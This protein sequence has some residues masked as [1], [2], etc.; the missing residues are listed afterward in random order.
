MKA[1]RPCRYTTILCF[2]GA[3]AACGHVKDADDASPPSSDASSCTPT[4]ADVPDDMFQDANCDGIDG[5]ASDAIFLDPIN[6]ADSYDGSQAKPKQ[7]LLGT[8]GAFMAAI[9][10]N[11]HN[12][13]VST[14]TL[15]ESATVLV[16]DGISVW[17]GY[18][19]AQ[20]WTRSDDI[21]HPLVDVADP[22]GVRFEKT[23]TAMT[24][25]R[26]DVRSAD[27]TADGASSYGVFMVMTT[28]DLVVSSSTFTA[29]N[30]GPGT[31]STQPATPTT[32][33]A[34]NGGVGSGLYT[35]TCCVAVISD[36]CVPGAPGQN[37]C[38][39][40][41]GVG[42]KCGTG[43]ATAGQGPAG[44]AAG[45]RQ[46]QGGNGGPGGPGDSAAAPTVAFGPTT[47]DGYAAPQ[48]TTGTDGKPGSGG[49]G[50]GMDYVGS[51]QCNTVIS[52]PPGHGGAAGGC[53]GPAAPAAGGGGGS[54]ALYLFDSSPTL[55]RVTLDSRTGGDGGK[56]ANGADGGPGGI[57]GGQPTATVAG[58]NGGKG[59]KGG[60]ASGGP[61]GPSICLEKAGSSTPNLVTTPT[62]MLGAAGAGGT[63]PDTT[64]NGP[65]GLAA[66]QNP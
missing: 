11:K 2:A 26:V 55:D 61:G 54:F 32:P 22:T 37:T 1:S 63:A 12:I 4:G 64:L 9:A 20:S 46:Q 39:F 7:H 51:C 42:T 23:A 13:F 47:M 10:T 53:G 6:G 28:N 21:E 60:M 27:A 41:G 49:G 43:A 36:T 14:G 8:S 19:A 38:A 57:G 34:A 16:P 40:A 35:S 25:D 18:D 31:D 15:S 45:L 33:L 52:I 59:G 44:G 3:L 65:A 29:G 5:D 62:C 56:G 66:E 17:G 58:G 50:G 48:G 30:G 24:W